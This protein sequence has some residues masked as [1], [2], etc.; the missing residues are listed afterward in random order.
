M[1]AVYCVDLVA[2]LFDDEAWIDTGS[3]FVRCAGPAN[4]SER[5]AFD[6]MCALGM[7]MSG[8]S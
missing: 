5:Y 2:V 7:L 8:R 4:V 3:D 6:S 1:D